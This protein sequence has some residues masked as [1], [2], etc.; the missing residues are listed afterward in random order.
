MDQ[1]KVKKFF[2]QVTNKSNKYDLCFKLYQGS[3]TT[4]MK[5]H[6][7]KCH[8]QAYQ[9]L[10]TNLKPKVIRSQHSDVSIITDMYIKYFIEECK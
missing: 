1:S 2:T 6:L 5:V 4:N 10:V 7:E 8:K 3:N 9:S